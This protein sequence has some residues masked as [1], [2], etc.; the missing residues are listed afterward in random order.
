MKSKWFKIV[1]VILLFGCSACS[2]NDE[3][4]FIDNLAKQFEENT[5]DTLQDLVVKTVEA[6]EYQICSKIERSGT[7]IAPAA[8]YSFLGLVTDINISPQNWDDSGDSIDTKYNWLKDSMAYQY[9]ENP[10][11]GTFYTYKDDGSNTKY[12]QINATRD[13]NNSNK[14]WLDLFTSEYDNTYFKP[15][16]NQEAMK[17]NAK[18]RIIDSVFSNIAYSI[19][20]NYGYQ[21]ENKKA[22]FKMKATVQKNEEGENIIILEP[23]DMDSFNQL[24]MQGDEYYTPLDVQ[25]LDSTLKIDSLEYDSYQMTLVLDKNNCIS[26]VLFHNCK[27]AKYQDKVSSS[28]EETV[29]KI[30]KMNLNDVDMN[31]IE[32]IFTMVDNGEL[33]DDGK[34]TD[35]VFYLDED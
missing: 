29:I 22:L 33:T 30:S 15:A 21:D 16:T 4:I 26:Q 13:D 14:I 3:K 28:E 19:N 20:N 1:L 12:Y 5:I 25:G 10:D 2:N 32:S 9:F 23:E 18:K 31:M 11:L 35:D 7:F 24:Y 6:N 27:T 34:H 8:V 17:Q